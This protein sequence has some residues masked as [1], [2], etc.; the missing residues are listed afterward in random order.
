[1]ILAYS[2][3]PRIRLRVPADYDSNFS[4]KIIVQIRDRLDRVTE[5]HLPSV[6]VLADRNNVE[7]L[8]QFVQAAKTGPRASN[9]LVR[10]LSDGQ[11][12]TVGQL[13]TSFS[14][15]LNKDHRNSVQ[16]TIAG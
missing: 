5:H 13:V 8:T 14:S 9:P 15:L 11:A 3:S 6:Q 4:W 1:M 7:E 10:L 16:R 12:N 2:N